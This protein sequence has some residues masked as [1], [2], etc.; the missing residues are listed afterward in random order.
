MDYFQQTLGTALYAGKAVGTGAF[1]LYYVFSA[2]FLQ[3]NIQAI[4]I[5]DGSGRETLSASELAVFDGDPLGTLWTSSKLPS[6][7]MV[8]T[9]TVSVMPYT[10]TLIGENPS[11]P[12]DAWTLL[13][14]SF[15]VQ[16]QP[17]EVAGGRLFVEVHF[18]VVPVAPIRQIAV[19]WDGQGGLSL[20][21]YSGDRTMLSSP[22][23]LP[24]NEREM[25]RLVSLTSPFEVCGNPLPY[26]PWGI[27]S[28]RTFNWKMLEQ[29]K[30]RV[31]RLGAAAEGS[32]RAVAKIE[33][34]EYVEEDYQQY[35]WDE[36]KLW[37]LKGRA[38]ALSTRRGDYAYTVADA[39]YGDWL[40]DLLE[41]SDGKTMKPFLPGYYAASTPGRVAPAKSLASPDKSAGVDALGMLAG[42]IAMTSFYD[43]V[44]NAAN[45]RT[46]VEVDKYNTMSNAT[47]KGVDGLGKPVYYAKVGEGLLDGFYRLARSDIE[48]MTVLIPDLSM[49]RQ[50]DLLVRYDVE[51]DPH[52]GIVVSCGWG[53]TPPIYGAEPKDL[54]QQ[55]M[56]VS[57]RRGFREVAIGTWGNGGG[58]FGGFTDSPESYQ[59]RWLLVKRDPSAPPAAGSSKA[60]AWDLLDTSIAVLN[61]R[62]MK[63]ADCPIIERFIPNTGEGLEFQVSVQAENLFGGEPEQEPGASGG[64]SVPIARRPI[65]R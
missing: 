10:A 1:Q 29:R 60:D 51:G 15:E 53:E 54:M 47:I 64:V 25:R 40:D 30:V 8:T 46:A 37:K 49:V 13:M 57:V 65:L 2:G 61:L 6:F 20:D 19:W 33:G 42:S 38:G 22:F 48:R 16:E 4:C 41:F 34:S 3:Q 45:V 9:P 28:P 39:T 23:F 17:L 36:P 35:Y 24:Y 59:V 55:I 58:I 5:L 32:T 43:A 12:L 7:S 31:N 50:G 26:A 11:F 63:S 62:L 52:V 56:V 21:S 14:P 44:L 18:P 27:D